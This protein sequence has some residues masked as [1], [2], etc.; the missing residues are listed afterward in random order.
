LIV[1][2]KTIPG[3]VDLKNRNYRDMNYNK[4]FVGKDFVK[5]LKGNGFAANEFKCIQLAQ[6]LI[7]N[8][9]I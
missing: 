8:K 4:S 9:L 1:K 3:G 6:K 2:A 5:W 7:E